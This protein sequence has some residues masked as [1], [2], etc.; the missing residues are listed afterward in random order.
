MN[1]PIPHTRVVIEDDDDLAKALRVTQRLLLQHP[2]AAQAL[3]AAFVHEGRRFAGTAEGKQWHARLASSDLIRRARVVWEV[4]TLNLLED[5][6]QA[7]LPSKLLDT[8][9]QASGLEGLEP[10][11]SRLIENGVG[12]LR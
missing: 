3:F 1:T 12:G 11:L 9:V 10:L 4:A 6:E 7:V 8:I 5:D 2:V